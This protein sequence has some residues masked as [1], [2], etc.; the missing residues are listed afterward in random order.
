VEILFQILGEFKM[1][2]VRLFEC[3]AR[4]E[5]QKVN[6]AKSVKVGEGVVIKGKDIDI[7]DNVT[8]G[9]NTTISADIIHIG[10]G[11]KIEENSKIILNG[12]NTRFSIGDNCLFGHDN[13]IIVPFFEAGDYVTVHNHTFVNG[14]NPVKI[15]SNVWIGQ[16]CILNS[17]DPLTIGNGVGIGTYSCV[18]THGGHGE[19]LE[20]C[21]IFKRAPVTIED[22]VWIVGSYNVISPGVTLGTKSVIL[23][24]SVVTKDVPAYA[25]V[26]GNPAKDITDK[27]ST[28]RKITLEEKYEMMK[29]FERDFV[30]AFY[31]Q[32]ALETENGWRIKE[33]EK[34]YEIIFLEEANDKN[35]KENNSTNLV[36]TKKNVV[37]NSYN[38]TTIFDLNTKTYTKK[39]TELEVKAIKFLLYS[40]A[41]FLPA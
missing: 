14:A 5:G 16:N 28:Y 15:G 24:G 10:F 13:K 4:V 22:D 19:L 40:K 23:T 25:C 37:T 31:K 12:Q 36:F 33:G 9:N 34:T 18:W 21:L 39:R 41:R 2:D 6:V 11:S 27:V 8:I 7:E 17:V 20:G 3:G 1:A 26:A 32:T 29:G 35:V 38:R 30:D